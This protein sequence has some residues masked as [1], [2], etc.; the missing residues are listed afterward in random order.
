M[1]KVDKEVAVVVKEEVLGRFEELYS[2]LLTL[3]LDNKFQRSLTDY[4]EEI[5][6]FLIAKAERTKIKPRTFESYSS[7]IYLSKEDVFGLEFPAIGVF[8][9]YESATGYEVTIKS[10][11]NTT[12]FEFSNRRKHDT[13]KVPDSVYQHIKKFFFD[14]VLKV[15]TLASKHYACDLNW[16]RQLLIEKGSRNMSLAL[17][18]EQKDFREVQDRVSKLKILSD[19]VKSK[20]PDVKNSDLL[21]YVNVVFLK[22]RSKVVLTSSFNINSIGRLE[23]GQVPDKTYLRYEQ[24]RGES[25]HSPEVNL[26]ELPEKLVLGNDY[27]EYLRLCDDAG[28]TSNGYVKFD[29]PM[30]SISS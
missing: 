1:Q 11:N 8:G 22:N 30:V 17:Y 26:G 16:K 15:N 24:I 6:S 20:L 3:Y 2:Y 9:G 29:T 13:L 5:S 23:Q 27:E 19:F 25:G 21:D 10:Q 7:L 4:Y 12:K 18:S 28:L 14:N